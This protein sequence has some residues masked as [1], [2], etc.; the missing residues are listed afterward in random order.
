[1]SLRDA[2]H[3]ATSHRL[4]ACS[5]FCPACYRE[6]TAGRLTSLGRNMRAVAYLGRADLHQAAGDH[7]SADLDRRRAVGLSA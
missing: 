2:L 5:E 6:S 7:D 1:M 4:A 3:R